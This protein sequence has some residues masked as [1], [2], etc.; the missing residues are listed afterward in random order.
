MQILDKTQSKSA[1]EQMTEEERAAVLQAG[2][3]SEWMFRQMTV[4]TLLD[5]K[6]GQV[7]QFGGEVLPVEPAEYSRGAV[8]KKKVRRWFTRVKGA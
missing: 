6:T 7:S 1:W 2:I 5:S 3:P 4:L 8:L